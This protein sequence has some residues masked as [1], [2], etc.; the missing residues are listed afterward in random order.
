MAGTYT[1]SLHN[2]KKTI[3][4]KSKHVYKHVR[5]EAN[6]LIIPGPEVLFFIHNSSEH[7]YH[8]YKYKK[9]TLLTF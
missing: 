8:D 6:A 9:S 1:V 7:V 4:K 2:L 5:D 3:R